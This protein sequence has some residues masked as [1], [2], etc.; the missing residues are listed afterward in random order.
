VAP[1]NAPCRTFVLQAVN[2]DGLRIQRISG[3][4]QLINVGENFAPLSLRVVDANANSVSG[5]PVQFLVDVYRAENQTV[6]VVSGDSVTFTHDEPVML[7]TLLVTV[8]SDSNGMVTQHNANTQEQPVR[9]VVAAHAG[10]AELALV[11]SSMWNPD[12]TAVIP[13]TVQVRSS[14]IS[15]PAAAPFNKRPKE[16]REVFRKRGIGSE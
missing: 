14:Q 9:V 13:S 2:N 8:F 16:P 5:V 6:R 4:Q 11:L 7:S 12:G 15:E 3:D 1:D 10:D